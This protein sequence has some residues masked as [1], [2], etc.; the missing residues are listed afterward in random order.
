MRKRKKVVVKGIVLAVLFVCVVITWF[1]IEFILPVRTVCNRDWLYSDFQEDYALRKKIRNA[2]HK[3]LRYRIGN[4]HDAFIAIIEVG[5]KDSIPY[6]IRALKW[7][8]V[9]HKD[10]VAKRELVPC[11]FKHCVDALE[12]LAGKKLG[13]EYETWEDWWEQTGRHLPF[14]EEKG[15]LIL[16]DEE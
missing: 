8:H 6:L 12:K 10:A 14:D 4:H 7:Q 3:I 11:T 16:Q 15:H 2:C 13:W 5:D 1:S 9:E